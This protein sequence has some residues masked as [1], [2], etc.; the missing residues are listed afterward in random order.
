MHNVANALLVYETLNAEDYKLAYEGTLDLTVDMLEEK[1]KAEERRIALVAEEQKRQSLLNPKRKDEEVE[2]PKV[3]V[4]PETFIE[5][6]AFGD[7]GENLKEK[8]IADTPIEIEAFGEDGED[9]KEREIADTPIE[10]E[11]FGDEENKDNK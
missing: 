11:A 8:E 7:D 4:E 6:E 2:V 1:K 10:I 9:P 3:H 5:K